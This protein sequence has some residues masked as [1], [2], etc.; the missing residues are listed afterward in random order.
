[1]TQKTLKPTLI[2]ALDPFAAAFCA[3]VNRR[4][5]LRLGTNFGEQNT[6]VQACALTGSGDALA[7]DLDLAPYLDANGI[8]TDFDLEA[9]RAR[10]GTTPAA[11][12]EQLFDRGQDTVEDAL[13]DVLLQARS[14]HDIEAAR[15]AG[16]EVSDSRLIYLVL[17]SVDSF[18]VGAVLRVA[19]IIRWLFSTRLA[20]ELH[21]LHALVLLP[22]LFKNHG[23]TDYA[24]TYGLL[25]KLDDAFINGL[26]VMAHLKPQ[27]FESC[28]VIDGRNQRAVGTGTLSENLAGYADA[29]VGLLSANP[30]DSMATPGVNARGRPPS[31]NSFGYGELYLPTDETVARLSAALAHDI[32]ARVFLGDDVPADPDDRQRLSD[33][34]RFVQSKDFAH[35]LDQVNRSRQGLA[36]W[37]P[38]K[39]TERFRPEA[40]G[41]YLEVLRRRH[42]EFEQSQMV[43]YRAALYDSV[44]NV[45]SELIT[46]LDHELDRR[47]NASP[48]GLRDAVEYLRIMV[49]HAVELRQLFGEKPQNLLS[50]LRVAEEAMDR[51]FGIQVSHEKS[52]ALLEQIQDLRSSLGELRIDLRLFPAQEVLND[53]QGSATVAAEEPEPEFYA[54]AE[55]ATVGSTWFDPE[56]PPPEHEAAPE[57]MSATAPPE[58]PPMSEPP[59]Q[60]LAKE[61]EDA[62]RRLLALSNEYKDALS[63]EDNEGH[64]LR[65]DANKRV[66]AQKVQRI[67]DTESALVKLSDELAQARR[68]H[69]E[70]LDEQQR[71]MRRHLVVRLSLFALA[72]FGV[73]LLAALGGIWPFTEL[74]TFAF[75]N[76]AE[77]TLFILIALLIY[78]GIVFMIFFRQLRPRIE[79]A[80]KRVRERDIQLHSA[81]VDLLRARN[82]LLQYK[83]DLSVWTIRR[84]T[85]LRLIETAHTRIQQFNDRIEALRESAELFAR[86]REE[87]RPLASPMRRPLLLTAD[88]DAYYHKTIGSIEGEGNN[89]ISRHNM[90]RSEVRRVTAE[91]FCAR[92]RAFATTRF[93]HLRELSITEAMLHRPDLV[94]AKTADL[95]LRE[96]DEA[97]ELLLRLR[98]S[99]GPGSSRLA[100]RDVT[101][102]ASP[103]ARERI[104]ESYERIRPRVNIRASEDDSALRVLTRCLY[105]PAFYIGPV[106][107]YRERYTRAPHKIADE[108]PDVLPTDERMNR[109][110]KRF[111]LALATG[112]IVRNTGGEYIFAG[113]GYEPFGTDRQQIAH[114]LSGSLGAQKLYEELDARLEEYLQ[115]A[116]SVVHKL[117]EFLSSDPDLNI[118]E[119][120]ILN[121]L[122]SEYF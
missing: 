86:E 91:E 32:T 57:E 106:E 10:L 56:V 40:P 22:D 27:P 34:K 2:L 17:S 93:E 67:E 11:D 107:F 103:Q 30:E 46:L 6:L 8:Y 104:Q 118:S 71:F 51:D 4:L 14:L 35:K 64:A 44:E 92:V 39:V 52:A 69:Q 84:D 37:Q 63:A 45:L 112:V 99:S 70:M 79:A 102:W 1:M 109:A 26:S 80:E 83:F 49:E 58:E 41:D 77:L 38:I 48:A 72:V 20:D 121:V 74:V 43:E 24:T 54:E 33:V 120:Q 76:F 9:M 21:T 94:P 66:L 115:T 81:S 82:A 90:P 28:W 50:V 75:D 117:H 16:Y 88:I 122:I 89:F 42:E 18:A 15:R 98:Q 53:S 19:R 61:I 3:E 60:R 7:L 87:T 13:S 78:A 73:P 113:G 110:Y 23:S 59:R 25:K 12:A 100:Q 47:A 101:L 105:F 85:I 31:Y 95:R 36:I 55:P 68:A 96:L 97:A 116:D 111:M 108:L 114:R 62:E 29:F 65:T 119:R 5:Q